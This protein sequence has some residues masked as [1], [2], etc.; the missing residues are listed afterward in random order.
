MTMPSPQAPHVFDPAH[1]DFDAFTDASST[2]PPATLPAGTTL[3]DAAKQ[4]VLTRFATDNGLLYRPVWQA[5][6]Y[7]GCIFTPF[8]TG[9][10]TLVRDNFSTTSGRSVALGNFEPSGQLETDANGKYEIGPPGYLRGYVALKMDRQLPNMMLISKHRVEGG[11]ALPTDP[12]P[13]QALP[14]E[15]DFDNYFTLYCPKE[16]EQD[17]LY[18]F[19]P[20]LMALL[21]DEATPFDV[22]LVDTWMFLYA[23][24]AFDPLDS[25][26]YR[27]IFQILDTIG[28]KVVGQTSFFTDPELGPAPSMAPVQGWHFV[29]NPALSEDDSPTGTRLK[30]K[31]QLPGL[32]LGL[33]LFGVGV[34]GMGIL[35]TW[36]ARGL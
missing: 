19:T 1:P 34:V 31:S 33:G 8:N 4:A 36:L 16:F 27:R 7:P 26:L 35:A 5:P 3:A 17:A 22:E 13:S 23:Q 25:S 9:S 24:R 10:V 32:Y 12:D 6:T 21:I 18:V 30:Q 2:P 11:T 29:P 20:D 15:G 14:L 28:T